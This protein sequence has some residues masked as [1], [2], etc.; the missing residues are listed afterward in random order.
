MVSNA[1]RLSSLSVADLVTGS[2]RLVYGS[3]SL[4]RAAEAM[5][6][7]GIGLLV[8]ENA[9][10][11]LAGVV[12]ERDLV[13]AVA[14]GMDL[15]A[16]RVGDLMADEVLTVELD[17]DVAQAARRMVDADVRHLVV[18][19]D[20]HRPIGVVSARDVMRTAVGDDVVSI[21]GRP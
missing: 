13:G 20:R 9:D 6:E 12:S 17:D 19:D 2:I 14:N 18:V 10:G 3:L 8:V 5:A 15:D 21:G 11:D 1:P 7:D 4:H 16:E